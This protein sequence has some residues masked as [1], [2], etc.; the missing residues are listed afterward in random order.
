MFLRKEQFDKPMSRTIELF[1]LYINVRYDGINKELSI[2]KNKGEKEMTV[3]PNLPTNETKKG[4]FYN[5]DG[6]DNVDL[7]E[8]ELKKKKPLTVTLNNTSESDKQFKSSQYYNETITVTGGAYTMSLHGTSSNKTVKLGNTKGNDITISNSGKNTI[9]A[10]DGGNT[11][12]INQTYSNNTITAGKEHDSY[13]LYSGTTKITDK[14]GGDHYNVMGGMNTINDKGGDN[15]FVF[16]GREYYGKYTTG[17]GTDTFDVTLANTSG[18]ITI[19]SGDNKDYLNIYNDYGHQN[20]YII[21]A[22]LGKGD[23][24]VRVDY[25][26]YGDIPENEKHYGDVSILN[27]KTGQGN[28][29]VAIY[30]GRKNNIDTGDGNDTITILAKH[31]TTTTTVKAGKGND[32][33]DAGVGTNIIY[34]EK[35]NDTVNLNG[36]TNTVYGGNDT[37]N[38]NVSF[39]TNTIFANADTI[40]LYTGTND[41]YTQKGGNTINVLS[42]NLFTENDDNSIYLQKGN[43]TV[44]LKGG[45]SS[46]YTEVEVDI[47]AGKNTINL[48][49]YT[50]LSLYSDD[51][52]K[53]AQTV[54]IKGNAKASSINLGKGNDIITHSSE[55]NGSSNIGVKAGAGNDKFYISNGF[56]KKFYGEE[57]NDYFEITSGEGHDAKGGKGNDTFIVSDGDS[58]KIHGEE[59]NDTITVSGGDSRI[60][61]GDE[62]KDTITVIDGKN[63]KVYC[64]EG[65]DTIIVKGGNTNTINGNLGK[66]TFT[67]SGGSGNIINGYEDND[68]FTIS[69]GNGNYIYGDVGNDTFNIN[70]GFASWI[71]G[72]DGDDIYNLNT[73]LTSDSAFI[74]DGVGNNKIN[75]SKNYKGYVYA[76]NFGG[77]N[78]VLSF[79]KSYKLTNANNIK[80]DG[81]LNTK[82]SDITLYVNYIKS[83]EIFGTGDIRLI[84]NVNDEISDKELNNHIVA[85][86]STIEK[87]SF[88]GKN[89]TLDLNALKADLV[90][91]FTDHSTYADSNAVFTGGDANDIN[92]LMAVY[93]E[94]TANCFIKA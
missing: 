82:N 51:N 10:G 34:G 59:G 48:D 14:G 8:L 49:E 23:D 88:G 24:E 2:T 11:F 28:D 4:Y 87:F 31:E 63:N 81:S 62:G 57:G 83:S 36:G 86:D 35:G 13:F 90:A 46:S 65:D 52:L 73:K 19:N 3:K 89:Y 25:V 33:I 22:D 47:S 17:N 30:A 60:I 64:G 92:S 68:T 84:K 93:T 41:V 15:H 66:D 85:F 6:L 67:I 77:S 74:S 61:Y 18:D 58:H 21:N 16:Q 9:T 42:N 55:E 43:N 56:Y 44:N 54:N 39:A 32:T 1:F 27:L 40:N 37:I 69:G 29:D 5:Y 70:G 26:N 50:A 75:V 45:Q 71:Y 91:W 78:D 80:K 20:D 7:S 72:E 12:R 53:T 79:D 38:A 76:S 94:N